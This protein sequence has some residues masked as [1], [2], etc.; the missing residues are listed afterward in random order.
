MFQ[1]PCE[2]PVVNVHN[3]CDKEKDVAAKAASCEGVLAQRVPIA[4]VKRE[5]SVGGL[6]SLTFKK[7]FGAIAPIASPY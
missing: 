4:F 7:E 1:Q 5:F 6:F 3:W 2:N